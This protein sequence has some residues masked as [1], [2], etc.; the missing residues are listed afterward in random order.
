V[1][2]KYYG[3]IQIRRNSVDALALSILLSMSCNQYTQE[4]LHPLAA[5]ANSRVAV[6]ATGIS[7]RV[8]DQDI[9]WL[10]DAYPERTVGWA[11]DLI[12][13]ADW[14]SR[15]VDGYAVFYQYQ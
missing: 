9:R 11:L 8:L 10:C 6:P 7:A 12:Q 14:Q 5:Y 2:G 1:N 15:E 4:M 13:Q 3:N